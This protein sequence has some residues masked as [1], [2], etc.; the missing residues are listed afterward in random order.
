MKTRIFLTG[1]SRGCIPATAGHLPP[2]GGCR[3]LSRRGFLAGCAA[4]VAGAT[5]LGRRMLA[6]P[7]LRTVRVR[8][9]FSHTSPEK[10]TWPNMWVGPD[11][12]RIW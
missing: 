2:C 1:T 10:I 4:C 5:V 8:L 3:G 9:V 11:S 6:A 7:A 12:S